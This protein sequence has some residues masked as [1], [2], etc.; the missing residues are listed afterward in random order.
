MH[1]GTLDGMPPEVLHE[2]VRQLPLYTWQ[3]YEVSK[4]LQEKV[5]HAKIDLVVRARH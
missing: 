2:I 1:R 4:V 3:L 5:D